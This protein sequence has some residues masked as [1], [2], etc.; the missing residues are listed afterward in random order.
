MVL[1]EDE[2]YNGF[3]ASAVVT[4]GAYSVLIYGQA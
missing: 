2:P 3:G 4:V 1:A